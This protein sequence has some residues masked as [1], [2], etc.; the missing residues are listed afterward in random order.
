[1][2]RSTMLVGL[3]GSL[4]FA[5]AASGLSYNGLAQTPQMGWVSRNSLIVTLTQPEFHL[6]DL[7]SIPLY[8]PNK[9]PCKAR[10][11]PI[12]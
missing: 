9:T 5:C 3:I 6:N 1:M 7:G 8:S 10:S 12:A 11:D 2:T 4:R